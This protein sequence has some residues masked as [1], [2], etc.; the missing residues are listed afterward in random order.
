MDAVRGASEACNQFFLAVPRFRKMEVLLWCNQAVLLYCEEANER[1]NEEMRQL[2][3]SLL[4][5]NVLRIDIPFRI[6]DSINVF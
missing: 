2:C 4:K 3:K 5:W 1:S 6:L